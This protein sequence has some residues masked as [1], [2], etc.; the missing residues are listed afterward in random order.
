[1]ETFYDVLRR[2]GITT[3]ESILSAM[4]GGYRTLKD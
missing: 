3:K 1:M 4:I 2:Q